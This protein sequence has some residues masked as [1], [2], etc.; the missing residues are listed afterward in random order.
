M[1]LLAVVATG[2]SETAEAGCHK[3][4]P[5]PVEAGVG[6]LPLGVISL[7]HVVDGLAMQTEWMAQR[8]YIHSQP[9]CFQTEP[10]VEEVFQTR[11]IERRRLWQRLKMESA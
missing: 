8:M 10:R 4:I 9:E 7:E 1:G 2:M 3:L 5:R 11:Q 6:S